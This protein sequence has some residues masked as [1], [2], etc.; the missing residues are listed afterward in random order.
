[1]IKEYWK[2]YFI[3]YMNN[4]WDL[5][6]G[7]SRSMKLYLLCAAVVAAS[8]YLFFFAALQWWLQV[9]LGMIVRA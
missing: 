6:W 8:V 7:G 1:M 9:A 4:I 3:I 2:F 5:R